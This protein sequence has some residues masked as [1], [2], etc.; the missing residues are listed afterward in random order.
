MPGNPRTAGIREFDRLFHQGTLLGRSEAELL[1]L[2]VCS[3][4][5][6]AFEA[7]VTRHGPMVLR[8]CCALLADPHDA[9]DAFQATFLVLSRRAGSIRNAKLLGPWLHRVARRV[10]SRSLAESSRRSRL[11]R[12]STDALSS[13]AAP[14]AT[15]PHAD[16]VALHEA[17]DHL[18]ERYRRV[19][20]LCDLEGHSH[21][22][23]AARLRCLIGTVKGR[24]SRAR[25]LL[26]RRLTRLGLAPAS[27][28]SGTL[29]SLP[30]RAFSVPHTLIHRTSRTAATFALGSSLAPGTVPGVALS[31][32]TGVLSSM[33]THQL[34]FTAL[35]G[36]LAL[37]LG[38]SGLAALRHATDDGPRSV[39]APRCSG[40]RLPTLPRIFPT[41]FAR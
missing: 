22:E 36:L 16:R 10:C 26:G 41:R 2:F 21:A 11:E 37:C 7:L 38:S 15:L 3:R 34:K 27:L 25:S 39:N 6:Y 31:L 40:A 29:L 32:A 12:P 1:D 8:T 19:I 20:I 17:I 13:L 9:D 28:L 30:T 18:P 5:E 4:D 33:A 23:A 24:Q 35:V 14:C